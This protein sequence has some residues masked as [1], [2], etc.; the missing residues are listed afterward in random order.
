MNSKI[1]IAPMV[2]RTDRHF[3]YLLRHLTPRSL[4]YTEMHTTGAVI[5][6]NR[7]RILGFDPMEKPLALQLAGDNTTDLS[8]A[9]KIAE[10]WPY[11]EINLNVGCPSDKVQE[12]NYGACLMA[13]PALVGDLVRAMKDSTSK[14]VTVKHRIGIDNRESYSEMVEFVDHCAAAGAD[15]FIIHARI[16]ILT[17]LNPK[18]NREIPPLRYEDVYQLKKEFPHLVIEING[19]IRNVSQVL[20][21]LEHTDGVMLGR[22]SYENP[23]YLT[24]IERQLYQDPLRHLTRRYIIEKMIPHLDDWEKQGWSSHKTYRHLTSLFYRLR[25]TKKWKQLLSPPYNKNWKGG[26]VLRHALDVMPSEALDTLEA[27]EDVD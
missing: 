7:D 25:G 27:P 13:H 23:Y 4:L 22:L 3:R 9:V 20:Q 8:K 1:S 26:D 14:P 2:D 6:G 18:E 21:H 10:E 11:D 12:A 16:A 17:G 19:G 15:R 24:E 5:F